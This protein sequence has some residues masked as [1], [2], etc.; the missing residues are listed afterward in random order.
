MT[1]VLT[2]IGY[3]LLV[4]GLAQLSFPGKA[5]GSLVKN[6]H[7][8]VVGSELI[9]QDFSAAAYFQPRPSAAETGYD[10][11]ASGGSNLGP[12][13]KR[14]RDRV[15]AEVERL[16]GEPGARAVPAEL[17]TAS[18]SGLD[19]HLGPQAALWQ[20]RRVAAARGLAPESACARWSRAGWKGAISAFSASRASTSCSSTSRS[21]G[22]SGAP[23]ASGR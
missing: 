16:R 6:D 10:A 2:G 11:P 21:I 22:S 5:N 13:S 14:L 20:V 17:V 7:G 1:L 15:A 4:T 23:S 19:P 18:A 9:G 8:A 12:T 3:P